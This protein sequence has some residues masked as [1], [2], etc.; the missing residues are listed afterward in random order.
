MTVKT[1][2]LAGLPTRLLA[3]VDEINHA[4]RAHA[5]GRLESLLPEGLSGA[6]IALLGLTF[7]PDTDDL[8]DAPAHHDRPAAPR[9][10]CQRGGL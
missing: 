7:K 2:T 4:Q 10:G 6:R 5:V 3:A 9:A 8:R 1:A